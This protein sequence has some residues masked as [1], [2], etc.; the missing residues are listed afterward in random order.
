LLTFYIDKEGRVKSAGARDTY[1][2]QILSSLPVY[3]YELDSQNK[4]CEGILF[5]QSK[6]VGYRCRHGDETLI[7]IGALIFE[8]YNS[9]HY[10]QMADP[11]ERKLFLKALLNDASVKSQLEFSSEA[12]QTVAFSRKDP[13]RNLLW[14]TVK[15][16][17]TH[18][19]S[20]FLKV[21][22]DLLGDYLEKPSH[23]KF[24]IRD[25]L[26]KKTLKVSGAELSR[27]GFPISLSPNGST[28]FVVKPISDK[29]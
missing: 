2:V 24:L 22:S 28:V 25:L 21:R 29:N 5:W 17:A 26:T 7:Q 1:P 27:R 13:E 23:D 8:D 4:E 14:I 18:A 6:V 15:T 12:V 11:K 10:S 20:I 3:Q 9:S 16:G 19:Q